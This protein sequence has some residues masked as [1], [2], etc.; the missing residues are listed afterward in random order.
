VGDTPD[1]EDY[2]IEDF[3]RW[4]QQRQQQYPYSLN[5]TSTHDT[6]RG[7]DGR[8]RVNVLTWLVEEWKQAVEAWRSINAP[9]I[10]SR[11]GQTMPT[12]EDEY[13][14]YQ[15]LIAGFP[16]D[17][18]VTTGYVERLKAYF[19]KSA[20][21]AKL[22]TNWQQPDTTYEEAGCRFI[23][24]ILSPQHDFLKSFQPFFKKVA[25]QAQLLSL[26]QALVKIT[27]PG[28]PDIYQ[29][30]EG[31]NTSY[32]DPD[33]RRP[34]D[35]SIYKKYVM[36]IKDRAQK[37]MGEVLSYI[38]DK[39]TEGLEKLYVTYKALQC[40]REWAAVFLHGNYI[41]LYTSTDC[42]I[43][44]YA[45]HYEKEWVLVIAPV[46]AEVV[47]GNNKARLEKCFL[48]LPTEAPVI[49]KHEFT[50]ETIETAGRLSIHTILNNFPVALLTGKI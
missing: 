28:V 49:W 50:G 37:S 12:L 9:C 26:T 27:A 30:C 22:F 24:K 35:Y 46:T 11:E 21:E 44:A 10:E 7:E 39:R 4:L 33:N 40:R 29:G 41:P 20:R 36:E 2:S 14:I 38:A 45:R 3:H 8:L 19:I 16:E 15:S 18:Q 42:G 25:A 23:E 17:E 13:F 48:T 1:K 31:W 47:T 34:V 43:I 5:A 6:K 32:V